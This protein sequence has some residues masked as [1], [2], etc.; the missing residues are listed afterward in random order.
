MSRILFFEL[1]NWEREYIEQS[2]KSDLVTQSPTSNSP[3]FEFVDGVLN[4]ET[5]LNL[6]KPGL[7]IWEFK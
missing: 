1:E 3:S 2:S 4:E 5:V 6:P 7:G